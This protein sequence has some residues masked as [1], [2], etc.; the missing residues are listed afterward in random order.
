MVVAYFISLARSFAVR[1]WNLEL[2]LGQIIA[3]IVVFWVFIGP[4]FNGVAY[5]G[6]VLSVI[7]HAMVS[8]N[9]NFGP[10]GHNAVVAGGGE[11]ANFFGGD[12]AEYG[13]SIADTIS[14]IAGS[15]SEWILCNM[16]PS[17]SEQGLECAKLKAKTK[18]LL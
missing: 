14:G 16:Y 3:W 17:N 15:G 8:V 4:L 5:F 18:T 13:Q 9:S 2:S 10:I 7:G 12:A 6:Y 1:L 11:P